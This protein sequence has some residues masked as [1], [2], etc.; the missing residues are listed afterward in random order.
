MLLS[1]SS[2]VTAETGGFL[3]VLELSSNLE[4]RVPM[5]EVRFAM[6]LLM[7]SRR[8]RIIEPWLDDREADCWSV[9]EVGDRICGGEERKWLGNQIPVYRTKSRTQ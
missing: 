5:A 3:A 8:S 9:I 6:L 1:S 2:G 4:M 7:L